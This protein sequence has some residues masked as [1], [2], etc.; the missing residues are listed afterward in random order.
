M[1]KFLSLVLL[2]AVALSFTACSDSRDE[3][4]QKERQ[5]IAEAMKDEASIAMALSD[6]AGAIGESL[7]WYSNQR[8]FGKITNS[9]DGHF[10]SNYDSGVMFSS[11][12]EEDV[13][14]LSDGG[15]VHYQTHIKRGGDKK[16]NCLIFTYEKDGKMHINGV[17]KPKGDI[18]RGLLETEQIQRIATTYDFT[19]R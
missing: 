3:R 19:K 17:Q 4:I 10:R 11:P 8:K 6:V 18:C 9:N 13:V 5:R 14:D 12:I 7:D 15:V 1:K 2:G 16:E